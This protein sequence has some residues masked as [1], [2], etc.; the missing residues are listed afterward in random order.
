MGQGSRVRLNKLDVKFFRQIKNMTRLG[1]ARLAGQGPVLCFFFAPAARP[2]RV[3][4]FISAGW[5]ARGRVMFFFAAW[6]RLAGL[7]QAARPGCKGGIKG[8]HRTEATAG[9]GRG[10]LPSAKAGQSRVMFFFGLAQIT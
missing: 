1:Q 9:Q 6:L 4:F 8:N 5:P 3:M 2:A 10:L 7:R